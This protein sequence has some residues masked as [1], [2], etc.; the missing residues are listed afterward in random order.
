MHYTS[1]PD[2]LAT[3]LMF[4][5]SACTKQHNSIND[6]QVKKTTIGGFSIVY[7]LKSSA[8]LLR[9]FNMYIMCTTSEYNTVNNIQPVFN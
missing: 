5:Y 1:N 2:Y 3:W 6:V 4:S 9:D 7:V 8:D